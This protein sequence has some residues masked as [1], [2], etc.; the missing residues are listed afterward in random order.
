VISTI[1][2]ETPSPPPAA[3][4]RI[5]EQQSLPLDRAAPADIEARN[6]QAALDLAKAGI[7]VFAV[8]VYFEDG[9]WK[10]KPIIKGWQAVSADPERVRGWWRKYPQAVPGIAL[11]QAGL[12]VID[13]DRHGGPDGV[14]AFDKLVAAR[15]GL[16]VGPMTAT[17]GGGLHYVFKQPDGKPLGNHDGVLHGQAINVRG[18]SGFIVGPGAVCRDGSMWCTA[19]GSPSLIEAFR[20]GAI[21]TIPSWFVDIVRPRKPDKPK[22][23]P[24]ATAEAKEAKPSPR[25]TLSS[26]GKSVTKREKA[27]ARGTLDNIVAELATMS[28]NSGRNE[29]TYRKAFAMGTMVARGW[30]DRRTVEREMFGACEK[31]GLVAEGDDLRGAIERGLNDSSGCPHDDL[32]DGRTKAARRSRASTR[33]WKNLLGTEVYQLFRVRPDGQHA[34]LEA[35]KDVIS[36]IEREGH[37][38]EELDGY[39]IGRLLHVTTEEWKAIGV[40]FGRHPSRFRPYDGT[41]EQIDEYLAR[42]REAKKPARA[43]VARERRARE[44]LER[45]QQPPINDLMT[46]RCKA[47]VAYAKRYPGKHRTGD[48]VSGLKRCDAFKDITEKRLRNAGRGRR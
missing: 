3:P 46:R 11:G 23:A 38:I 2:E 7:P 17:A 1:E 4:E 20:N 10:K 26:P 29:M 35:A 9:R 24:K 43:Q 22:K 18:R 34:S 36:G 6:L 14:A 44:K 33:A 16:P 8:R 47:M 15:G 39:A 41:P 19:A 12:V 21:P 42:V 30:I 13:A 27:Y 31:N 25:S 45:E 48:L 32:L 28:P 40:M 5:E 37:L